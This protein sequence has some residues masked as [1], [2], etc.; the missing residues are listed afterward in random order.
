MIDDAYW[1]ALTIKRAIA[2]VIDALAETAPDH[3]AS[4]IWLWHRAGDYKIDSLARALRC[5]RLKRRDRINLARLRA[6]VAQ[7]ESRCRP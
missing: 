7:M 1:I 2:A 4:A 3:Q 6:L 5:A